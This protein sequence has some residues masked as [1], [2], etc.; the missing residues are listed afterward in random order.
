MIAVGTKI[1]V[2]ADAT[3]GIVA[4]QELDEHT[5]GVLLKRGTGVG[6]FALL[7][8]SAFVANAD[9]VGIVTADVRAGFLHGTKGF[10]VAITADV[11][12]VSGFA[13][14]AA[15]MVGGKVVFRIAAIAT[16][17]GTV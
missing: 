6:G 13:E 14:S 9:A 11:I 4:Q 2:T 16:G 5:Q 3:A 10:D 17:S 7:V 1:A 8:Q 12:V 15:D